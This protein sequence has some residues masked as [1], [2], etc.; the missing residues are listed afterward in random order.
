M[1]Q[2]KSLEPSGKDFAQPIFVS[3]GVIISKKNVM[4]SDGSHLKLHLAR[5]KDVLQ[6]VAFGWGDKMDRINGPISIA[7]QINRN[8]W[9]EVITCNFKLWIFKYKRPGEFSRP[10]YY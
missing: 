9:R 1:D 10:F 2:S 5:H 8:S 7:Y 3:H 6:A 4:G